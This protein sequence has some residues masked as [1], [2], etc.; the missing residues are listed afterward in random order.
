[1]FIRKCAATVA[2]QSNEQKQNA[3]SNISKWKREVCDDVRSDVCV[4]DDERVWPIQR[5]QHNRVCD[6]Y[7][8]QYKIAYLNHYNHSDS[9]VA[10]FLKFVCTHDANV[11]RGIRVIVDSQFE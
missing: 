9:I 4:H 3:D 2:P 11:S 7:N 8:D 1:M 10:Y 6:V 5:D